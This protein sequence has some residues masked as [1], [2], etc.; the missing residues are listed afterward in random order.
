MPDTGFFPQLN[1]EAYT[2][3]GAAAVTA[4]IINFIPI[5]SD[6]VR[7]LFIM[8]HEIGHVF[9]TKLSNG[10]TKGFW[11]FSNKSGVA[12]RDGGIT[13]WV[14]PAGYLGTTLFSAG[15][16]LLSGFPVVA[17]YILAI[18]GMFLVLITL[19]YGKQSRDQDT[20]RRPVTLF[21]GLAF[22]MLFISTAWLAQP[23]WSLFL[24]DLLAIQG[25]F[26]SLRALDN[27]IDLVRGGDK[28]VDPAKMPQPKGCS[29]LIW[30][31][32]WTLLSIFLLGSAIWFTWIRSL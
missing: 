9:A 13:F 16:I 31:K 14:A 27:V 21:V 22:G 3:L 8:I 6:S 11:V 10:E 26:I 25:A 20:S 24:L 29:P 7:L 32:I 1:N 18:L 23:I 15:L 2:V 12:R 5:L 4:L 19:L 17:P 28:E 30:A